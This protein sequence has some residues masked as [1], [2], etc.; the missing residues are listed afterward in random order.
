MIERRSGRVLEADPVPGGLNSAIA[1]R[2]RTEAET[3]FVKGLPAG[4]P[5]VWTQSREAAINP[6]VHGIAPKLVW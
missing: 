5:R 4:H 2:V 6:H 1:A 3:L